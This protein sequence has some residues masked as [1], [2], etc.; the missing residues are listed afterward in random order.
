MTDIRPQV[1]EARRTPSRISNN[2][3]NKTPGLAIFK[4][5]PKI[6]RRSG[7]KPE[8]KPHLTKKEQR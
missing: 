7:K 3:K 6:K 2:S 1:E 4:L 8:K 5:Q